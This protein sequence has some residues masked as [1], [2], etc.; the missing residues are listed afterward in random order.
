MRSYDTPRSETMR[1]RLTAA[2]RCVRSRA[3]CTS[4]PGSPA[5]NITEPASS[6]VASA[7]ESG[8]TAVKQCA[9]LHIALST[10]DEM[11]APRADEQ[12][13]ANSGIARASE[14][15]V[16]TIKSTAPAT[17]ASQVDPQCTAEPRADPHA[18]QTSKQCAIRGE[19]RRPYPQVPGQPGDHLEPRRINT[20]VVRIIQSR[21]D[22]RAR[23][24]RPA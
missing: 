14:R 2:K 21:N 10:L 19:R 18:T 11:L 20:R 17:S 6:A 12:C 13:A 24:R 8:R 3:G 23:S 22:A 7:L 5:P 9:Q 16:L 15:A 4:V 1:R